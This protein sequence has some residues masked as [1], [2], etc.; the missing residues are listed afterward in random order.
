MGEIRL[1]VVI[2]STC[3][4]RQGSSSSCLRRGVPQG[5]EGPALTLVGHHSLQLALCK[6]RAVIFL[7]SLCMSL[8]SIRAESQTKWPNWFIWLGTN[9]QLEQPLQ[10]TRLPETLTLG[11]L[12]EP[13][14]SLEYILDS[15]FIL[16]SVSLLV[17]AAF[18]SS[19]S[20]SLQ[21]TL[22]AWLEFLAQ[23]K[24]FTF[25]LQIHS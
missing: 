9:S 21:I 24:T 3:K 22:G 23:L 16:G 20:C 4:W 8:R 11:W 1:W 17:S 13:Q 14:D 18:S 10:S 15:T 6:E 25:Q 19:V 7:P 2:T 12:S 5:Q